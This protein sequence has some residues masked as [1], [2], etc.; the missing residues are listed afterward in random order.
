VQYY[1]K[2][3]V[4]TP[5]SGKAYEAQL[6]LKRLNSEHPELKA[7]IPDIDIF[8]KNDTV[9]QTPGTMEKIND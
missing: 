5:N 8:R 4:E 1:T 6:A 3:V 2:I 7:P 9:K